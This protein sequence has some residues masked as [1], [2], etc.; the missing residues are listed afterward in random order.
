MRGESPSGRIEMRRYK[1]TLTL[2]CVDLEAGPDKD[3]GS[4]LVAVQNN[5]SEEGRHGIE[6]GIALLGIKF[7][8]EKAEQRKGKSGAK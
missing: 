3:E 1:V 7:G 5:V 4:T 2:E 6:T 8:D